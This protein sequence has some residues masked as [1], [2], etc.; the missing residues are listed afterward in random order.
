LPF[1]EADPWNASRKKP[2]RIKKIG[3]NKTS[4]ANITL[5]PYL[6]CVSLLRS[7]RQLVEKLRPKRQNERA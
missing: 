4:L 2:Y 6:R 3:A 5:C 7:S 1:C